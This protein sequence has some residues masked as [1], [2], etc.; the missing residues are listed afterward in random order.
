MEKERSGLR[1]RSD[2]DVNIV[3]KRAFVHFAKWLRCHYHF[4]KRVPVYVKKSYYIISRSKE[5]VSATFFGPFDKQYEPYIR[6]AT[7]DFYDL[8]KEH[9]RRDAILLTLQSLAHELQ[10]YYQWLDDEEFLEDE[11][12]EG[13]GELIREYIED[14]FEEFW[15]SLDG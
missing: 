4:P 13:A 5:Q 15:S 3:L 2:K 8:E 6:I 1:I 10:H 12:E 11:A 9:G 14:K 7:G